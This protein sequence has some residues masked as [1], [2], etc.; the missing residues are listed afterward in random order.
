MALINTTIGEIDESLLQKEEGVIDDD[1]EY[2]TW[3]QY[4]FDGKIV[5]RS[6]QTR[7]KK[8]VVFNDGVSSFE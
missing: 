5:Y 2:T 1:K 7:F 4:W 8:T 6:L 3:I